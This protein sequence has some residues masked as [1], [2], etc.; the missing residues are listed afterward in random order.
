M[1]HTAALSPLAIP[2]ALVAVGDGL[3]QHPVLRRACARPARRACRLWRALRLEEAGA[4]GRTM[5]CLLQSS[6]AI[7]VLRTD[8]GAG[9]EQDLADVSEAAARSYQQRRVLFSI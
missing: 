5:S 1:G 3:L 2:R 4:R 8:V 9:R 7:D 6:H